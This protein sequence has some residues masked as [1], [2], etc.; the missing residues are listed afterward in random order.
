MGGYQLVVDV[1]KDLI[2]ELKIT[3]P[4]CL[5]L[6]HGTSIESC[7]K[8][9]KAG[10]SSVMI[11]AS[12][13]PLSKNIEMTKAVMKVAYPKGITV[14]GEIGSFQNLKEN[15]D[16]E[17]CKKYIEATKITYLAPAIGNQHGPI[18][19]INL[20]I[21]KLKQIKKE[22]KCNL[23][24]HGGSGLTLTQLKKCIDAG[25]NK[26]NI[27]TDLQL[28]WSKAVRSYLQ[29]NPEVYDPRKIISSGKNAIQE[30]I[31]EKINIAKK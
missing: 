17:A 15:A 28:A 16:I 12:K 1:V 21:N 10:F 2:E 5:H 19:N 20:D 4:V 22:I 7:E 9:I 13:Y 25:I 26:I 3:I 30:I 11:D 23:V 18:E 27:N 29:N 14:E 8:A 31:Q 24:L 6:D